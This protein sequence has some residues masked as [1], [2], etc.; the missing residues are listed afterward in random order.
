MPLVKLSSTLRQYASG[1]SYWFEVAP[2]GF[3]TSTKVLIQRSYKHT[4]T[5]RLSHPLRQALRDNRLSLPDVRE[6]PVMKT[7]D[8]EVIVVLPPSYRDNKE[9]FVM[10]SL[11]SYLVPDDIIKG[12]IED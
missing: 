10:T 2:E 6:L 8:N 5:I 3:V 12:L 7:P 1:C 11:S 9:V 4:E